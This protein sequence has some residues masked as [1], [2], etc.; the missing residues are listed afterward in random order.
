MCVTMKQDKELAFM[1][2][3]F[4]ASQSLAQCSKD[5]TQ[6]ASLDP[7]T[8]LRTDKET[9]HTHY[10][11]DPLRTRGQAKTKCKSPQEPAARVFST[12]RLKGH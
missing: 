1:E 5:F 11:Q 4:T 9:E 6:A 12:L 8:A 2:V 7:T 3:V 10:T